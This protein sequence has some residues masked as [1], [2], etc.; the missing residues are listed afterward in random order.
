MTKPPSVDGSMHFCAGQEAVPLGAM[1]AL[2]PDDQV[3]T[4]RGHGWAI[5]SGLDERSVFAEICQR[6]EGINGGRAGSAYMMGPGTR[7]V[8]ENSIVGAGTTIACGIAM[9]N[10]VQKNGRVV[11][12]TIG[13]G[14]LNQGGTHEAFAFAAARSLP[15]IFVV[16]NNAWSEMTATT[17]MFRVERLAQ[18]AAGYGFPSATIDGT[19]PVAVRDSVSLA[20]ERPARG[21]GP[22]LLEFRVPRLW[23]HYNR[24]V[25]HYR[26]KVTEPRPSSATRSWCSGSGWSRPA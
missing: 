22:S 5:A 21:D 14:A 13:D 15:V 3:A 25:E 23:G 18:R 2:G 8:G 4:Y 19:D 12:V 20:A 16:E 11:A 6:A 7:F 17:D 26:H 24:D 10:V 1:A 9:A